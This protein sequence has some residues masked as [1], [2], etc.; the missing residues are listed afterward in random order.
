MTA[1]LEPARP[2]V[3]NGMRTKTHENQVKSVAA[4]A[5][6][7]IHASVDRAEDKIDE[8]IDDYLGPLE[9][10]LQDLGHELIAYAKRVNELTGNQVRSHPVATFGAA[11]VAGLVAARMLKH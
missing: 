5:A 4:N 1:A 11:F 7:K 9:T 6:K 3:E 2:Y 10:Q 8:T